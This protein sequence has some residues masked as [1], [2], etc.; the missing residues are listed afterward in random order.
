MEKNTLSGSPQV[1]PM[2][3]L[4]SQKP[5]IDHDAQNQTDINT[6]NALEFISIQ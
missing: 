6:V 5:E 4:T 2:T 3:R 1:Y